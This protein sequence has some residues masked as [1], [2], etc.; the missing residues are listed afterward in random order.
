MSK[1]QVC[2]NRKMIGK[3]ARIKRNSRFIGGIALLGALSLS[4]AG[5]HGQQER[6]SFHVPDTFDESRQFEL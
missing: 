1:K 2:E 5:C 3:T 6:V 4:L